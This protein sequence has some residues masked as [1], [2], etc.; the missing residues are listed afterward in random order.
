MPRSFIIGDIHGNYKPMMELFH[1]VSLDYNNDLLIS[2]GDLV[3][4]GPEPVRVV[5]ELM[6]IRHFIFI[7]GNHDYWFREY[8]KF[9]TR[10]AEWLDQGGK[11]TLDNYYDN[12]GAAKLHLD[13]FS[14]ALPYYLDEKNR[15]FVHA[16]FDGEKPFD[17]QKTDIQVLL[18]DRKLFMA[19]MEHEEN[20]KNFEEF[21]EIYIGHSPTQ[22][23]NQDCPVQLSNVF[24]MDTGAGH[25][26]FLSLMDLNTKEYWQS[27]C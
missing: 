2:L 4:R 25:R 26:R 24:M 17:L 12:P 3:D 1:K 16:G 15:L 18:W 10:A 27:K 20:G 9:G 21:S 13:F 19:A 6:K 23:L 14:S 11:Q 7:L 22:L 8:L 5:D